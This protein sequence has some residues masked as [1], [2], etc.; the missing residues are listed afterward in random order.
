MSLFHAT[1]YD[2]RFVVRVHADIANYGIHSNQCRF[3]HHLG[4]ISIYISL[5]LL[6]IVLIIILLYSYYTY[7]SIFRFSL[8]RITFNCNSFTN[9][10]IMVLAFSYCCYLLWTACMLNNINSKYFTNNSINYWSH[11]SIIFCFR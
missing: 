3:I 4:G 5:P 10:L 1:R 9:I 11:T 2:Y 8:C 6:Y 7:L